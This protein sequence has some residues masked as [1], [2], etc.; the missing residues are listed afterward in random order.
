ML[1]GGGWAAGDRARSLRVL[2]AGNTTRRSH[3]SLLAHAL[4]TSSAL[5]HVSWPWRTCRYIASWRILPCLVLSCLV[6]RCKKKCRN[7]QYKW[8]EQ[9]IVGRA[10]GKTN[11]RSAMCCSREVSQCPKG[12]DHNRPM[13]F[14][15]YKKDM[16]NHC[17]CSENYIVRFVVRCNAMQRNAM[18]DSLEYY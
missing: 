16:T 18:R 13:L 17:L 3:V 11:V 14:F 8:R 7:T 9:K 10:R 2:S 6:V 4:S 1:S 15:T 5:C 12:C